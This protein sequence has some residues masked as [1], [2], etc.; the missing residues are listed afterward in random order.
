MPEPVYIT[1]VVFVSSQ[2]GRSLEASSQTGAHLSS[3]TEITGDME[4]IL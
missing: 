2:I 4:H 1:A 3:K